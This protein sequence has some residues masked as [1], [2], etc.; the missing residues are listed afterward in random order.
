[1]FDVLETES[2]AV[3]LFVPAGTAPGEYLIEVGMYR[4]G[5]LARC[6]TLDQDGLPVER[7][8]L[9]TVRVEP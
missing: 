9:G 7:V 4:A 8:V 5:D 1:M 2:R 3:D 6:L